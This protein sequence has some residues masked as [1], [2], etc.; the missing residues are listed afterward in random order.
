MKKHITKKQI[1]ELSENAKKKLWEWWKPQPGDLFFDPMNNN[2]EYDYG[3]EGGTTGV[4]F[5]Y[6]IKPFEDAGES[7]DEP[8]FNERGEDWNPTISYKKNCLPLLSISQMLEFL[9]CED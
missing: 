7:Y 8:A 9:S 5:D 4:I 1:D 6:D 2:K 3:T